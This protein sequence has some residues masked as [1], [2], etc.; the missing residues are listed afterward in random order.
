M[1]YE[2]VKGFWILVAGQI[3]F[4]QRVEL[5]TGVLPRPDHKIMAVPPYT[6]RWK[7]PMIRDHPFYETPVWVA[8]SYQEVVEHVS[9]KEFRVAYREEW[10]YRVGVG[11]SREAKI[12]LYWSVPEDPWWIK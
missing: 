11:Y 8:D 7:I 6:I 3:M 12:F 1:M 10:C 4:N 2:D 9:M 5:A